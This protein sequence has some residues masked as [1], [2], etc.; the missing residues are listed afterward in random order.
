[1]GAHR[2]FRAV[3]PP[4]PVKLLRETLLVGAILFGSLCAAWSDQSGREF[5][6]E[7]RAWWAIQPVRDPIVPPE[8]PQTHPVDAFVE[9]KRAA[10]GLAA[11]PEAGPEE[12]VRRAY[13]DLHGLPPTPEEID[14]FVAEWKKDKERAIEAL[15]DALLASPRYGERWA[16]HWLDVVRY[17]ES[18]GYREDAFRPAA[19]RY[20]D[21]VIRAFNEDKP[22]DQFVREQL[23]ADE[24]AAH[25]PKVLEATGFLRLGIYE[26]NQRDAEGQ[27][28]IMINEIT[29]LTGE[30]FLGVGLA[31]A[32]CHDHK[33][34]PLLQRDYFALQAF[35]GSTAWPTDRL[36]GT[37]DQMK[38]HAEWAAATAEIRSEMDSLLA[39]ARS[40]VARAAV[41]KFPDNVQA[42]Y[43][44]P[45]SARSSY[46]QQ[47][48]MLVQRQ[49]DRE[50]KKIKGEDKLKK[51]E[52]KLERYEELKKEL[53]KHDSKKPKLPVAF[54]SIDTGAKPAVTQMI[55]GD[56]KTEVAPAFLTLLGASAPDINP[57][58]NTTGRRSALATWIAS[59]ENPFTAR[60]FVNR[61]WQHHF[62]RGLVATPN[63]FGT[64]GEPPSH[65]GL[66]DWLASRFVE[67]GWKTK[68]MHRILMTSKVYRQTARREP[69][70]AESRIDP[71]D[72]LLW[73]HSPQRLSAEQV[74][75]AMLSV[76]GELKHRD[77]GGASAEGSSPVRSIYVKKRR[78]TPDAVLN[79]F[80]APAGFDSAPERP[81]TTTPTQSL[82]LVNNDWP[83][84]R[85]KAFAKRVLGNR[86]E[87]NADVVSEACRL[88]WG[89]TPDG[90]E[91]RAAL[92]FIAAQ[93]ADHAKLKPP[94]PKLKFPNETGLRP[95]TQIFGRVEGIGLGTRALWLQPGSRFEQLHLKET[96]FKSDSFTFEAVV[97]LD[98]IHK[99]ASVN[100][101]LSRWNG[102]H[103]QSGWA[104]GVTSAKSRYQPR[105]LI[106]QLIGSNPGGDIEYEVVASGLRVPLGRPVFISVAI[107]PKP[108][109]EGT[110]RFQLRDLSKKD[111]EL[112]REE[113]PHNIAGDI[114]NP[115]AK[116]LIGGRDQKKNAHLWDGQV[117]RI[118]IAG[119]FDA[120]FK[121]DNGNEPISGSAWLKTPAPPVAK[122]NPTLAAMADF[123][124]ALLSSNEFLY[125]H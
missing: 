12:F 58:E 89:R 110:I 9:R 82:L 63:D 44:K 14:A 20:R 90:D 26:W 31:C 73:R 91:V 101:L 69:G 43:D 54:V 123:C 86:K 1:M 111:T 108:K 47:I 61:I 55:S 93:K 70:E 6:D 80:D 114:Q 2:C 30:V 78:N 15:I 53:A 33:F 50:V 16:Q 100:T 64:L 121:G 49:V 7:D 37:P 27:R 103:G 4:V 25:D 8:G 84:A 19:H 21:Y 118:A 72:R 17:A 66:L 52:E 65:P 56:R 109:G 34:D 60:V 124:H 35:L 59:A 79:C 11:A 83:R 112:H 125:L 76:S 24:F 22:Y 85:A 57:R 92:E 94:A 113:V 120:T 23:A 87:A 3:H 42:M 38:A 68:P 51:D 45:E 36:L 116:L 98:A 95:I 119:V 46:E 39:E 5:T 40:K 104:I 74:R 71:G 102:D 117:G 67:G 122:T 77:N 41:I 62:G 48:A 10:A 18:D 97:Q 81:M 106:V 96:D 28:E 105:N 107:E 29:G 115:K 13:F 88:A 32:R 99:D 75:D